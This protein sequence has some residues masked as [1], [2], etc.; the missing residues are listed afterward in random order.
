MGGGSSSPLCAHCGSELPAGTRFC[1]IC[2]QSAD[3]PDADPLTAPLDLPAGGLQPRDTAQ[4]TVTAA[5]FP[6]FPA[7]APGP[8]P[9]DHQPTD[10]QPPAY[11]PGAHEP[12][13]YQPGAHEPA[14]YQPGAHE[15]AGYQPGA[16]EPAGYQPGAYEPAGYQ[17]GAHAPAGYQPGAHQPAD[18]Q[19]GAYEQPGVYGPAGHQPGVYGQP[20]AYE[21]AGYR[22]G[23][24]EAR[25]QPGGYPPTEYRPGGYHAADRQPRGYE[26]GGYP[27][28]GHRSPPGD[29]PRRGRILIGA[30]AVI[31]AVGGVTAGLLLA[32][33]HSSPGSLAG[34]GQSTAARHSS[35]GAA[36][37]SGTVAPTSPP[38]SAPASAQQGA[39]NLAALLSQSVSDRSAIN[40]AYSDVQNCG[41]T[42]AQDQATF[43]QAVASRQSLLSRL[44]SMPDAS[45]LPATMITS[46]T[47][48]WQ[49]SISADQDYAA[50]AKDESAGCTPGGSDANLAAAVGPGNQATQ[51]KIAFVNSWNPIAQQYGLPT[52]SQDQL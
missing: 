25:D 5:P 31:V 52:Y 41:P 12:A 2:G 18:H 40:N 22:P 49:A 47:Q 26:P 13:G 39:H 16:H 14:G 48:A 50:W 19:P 35:P 45:A 34:S 6:A 24:Y 43:Q 29:G 21:P 37:S 33:G 7:D 27:P 3:G 11:Q 36:S 28:P 20:G 42:L 46:L 44:G 38:A 1:R 9:A 51:N 15:P 4:D 8:G 23:G 17:P 32:R 30:L 10:W